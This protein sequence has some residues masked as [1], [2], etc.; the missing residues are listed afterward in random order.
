METKVKH[1]FGIQIWKDGAKFTGYFIDNK[2]NG[3]GRFNHIDGDDYAGNIFI[4]YFLFKV[5]I[6]IKFNLN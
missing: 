3:W 4:N 5:Y 2:A 1:G 6:F